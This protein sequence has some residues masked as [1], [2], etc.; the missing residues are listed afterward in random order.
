MV[1]KR[2]R[3]RRGGR[4]KKRHVVRKLTASG[5]NR[6]LTANRRFRGQEV[7]KIVTTTVT[8]PYPVRIGPPIGT[9]TTAGFNNVKGQHFFSMA[10]LKAIVAE[11]GNTATVPNA[12]IDDPT[13]A[14][15]NS[16]A[17]PVKFHGHWV[18]CQVRN[19]SLNPVKIDIYDMFC[20]QDF[21]T[22]LTTYDSNIYNWMMSNI[23]DA[24][25]DMMNLADI[26]LTA[27]ALDLAAFTIGSASAYGLLLNNDYF[28]PLVGK[29]LKEYFK[30]KNT[31]R[32]VLA[33]G[34]SYIWTVKGFRPY[35][36]YP[37]EDSVNSHSRNQTYFPVFRTCGEIG[38]ASDDKIG[39]CTQSLALK[40]DY[41][42]KAYR[43]RALQHDFLGNQFMQ[44]PAAGTIILGP[45]DDVDAA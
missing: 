27:R 33:P 1:F 39:F 20:N 31:H 42:V 12:M 32:V 19:V 9:T 45:S 6:A 26:V 3:S 28:S 44:T 23:Y 10:H 7:C 35:T 18:K 30:V 4:G 37:G 16:S 38:L 25:Y 29:G 8:A 40:F 43:T 17:N 41:G 14:A 21:A 36:Y 2:K 11:L 15:T 34:Q 22:D 24:Y 5:I 13:F